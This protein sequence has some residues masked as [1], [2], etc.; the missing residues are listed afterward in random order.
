MK[1]SINNGKAG[2]VQTKGRRS[3]LR[4]FDYLLDAVKKIQH[5][6]QNEMRF[7]SEATHRNRVITY[8]VSGLKL[9]TN[10]DSV[11]RFLVL[12]QSNECLGFT[13]V[14]LVPLTFEIDNV[15]GIHERT[16]EVT[17]FQEGDGTVR[18]DGCKFLPHDLIRL[19]QRSLH[20]NAGSHGV[21]LK[22]HLVLFGFEQG[23]NMMCEHLVSMTQNLRTDTHVSFLFCSVD[24]LGELLRDDSR[25]WGA[26]KVWVCGQ[27]F[28]E[29]VQ[30]SEV[31]AILFIDLF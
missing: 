1:V 23:L 17:S 28:G 8:C 11:P 6:L 13:E 5:L 3:R 9:Q 16:E 27:Q 31:Q 20:G 29:S 4:L 19:P 24:N 30:A 14:T 18:E 2:E 26:S 10:L 7:L 12:L 25:R 15:F 22:S 21:S